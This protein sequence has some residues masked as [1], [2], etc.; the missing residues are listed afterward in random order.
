MAKTKKCASLRTH[1]RGRKNAPIVIHS[2]AF[3]GRGVYMFSAKRIRKSKRF[4]VE[5]C[6]SRLCTFGLA[7]FALMLGVLIAG[8]CY[9]ASDNLSNLITVEIIAKWWQESVNSTTTWMALFGCAILP[10]FALIAKAPQLEPLRNSNGEGENAQT[11]MR[12][13]SICGRRALVLL[14]KRIWKPKWFDTSQSPS[15]EHTSLLA[16]LGLMF[17]ILITGGI[18][19]LITSYCSIFP[20]QEYMITSWIKRSRVLGGFILMLFFVLMAKSAQFAISLH[21]SLRAFCS[22]RNHEP[23]ST[24]PSA[25]TI[26]QSN[27]LTLSKCT[28]KAKR[29]VNKQNHPHGCTH[30]LP[31]T[32]LML[33]IL[34]AGLCFQVVDSSCGF[35]GEGPTTKW[36]QERL[37]IA[38]WN[39][40]S[41]TKV[42][43]D[44]CKRLNY[45][46]LAVT[47]LWKSAPK[48]AN[49]TT[50]WTYGMPAMDASGEPRFPDDRAGGVGILLSDRA[51]TKYMSHGSPCSRICWVRLRGPTT[52]LFVVA[53]Y[54]PHRARVKPDQDD[55]IEDLMKLSRQVPTHDCFIVLGDFNEQLPADVEHC[56]GEWT[57][58]PASANANKILEVMRIHNLYAIN[59]SYQQKKLSATY[60]AC[61]EGSETNSTYVGREVCAKYKQKRINGKVTASAIVNGKKMYEMRFEDGYKMRCGT[62]T[63][64]RWLKPVKK[65]YALKQLDYILHTD[66]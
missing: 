43:F 62:N 3:G 51:C 38:T 63:L 17:G 56:T 22:A 21:P 15:R 46:V 12:S 28:E 34:T 53:V 7:L 39:S 59:T 65:K 60:I 66:L 45:D 64:R 47:E 6:R 2:L 16:T 52:N 37:K 11:M 48:F 20:I 26:V 30:G 54:M 32:V 9:Q 44:Y 42:R 36:R 33:G 23:T 19:R 13:L 35:P 8:L 24:F 14:S 1:H 4:D 57:A 10:P 55:T 25:V 49:G 50:Q 18:L 5:N 29:S 41:M 40:R 58:G 27:N 31:T 61:T